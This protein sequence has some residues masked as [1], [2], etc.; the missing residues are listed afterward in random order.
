MKKIFV[1]C[2][3]GLALSSCKTYYKTVAA[4]HYDVDYTI[5]LDK[6]EAPANASV[7]FGETN[8][9]TRQDIQHDSILVDSYIYED[10]YIQIEWY[11]KRPVFHFSLRN[12]SDYTIKLN[13]DDMTFVDVD[14]KISKVMHQGVKYNERENSQVATNIPKGAMLEDLILPTQNVEFLNSQWEEKPLLVSSFNSEDAMNA[15]ASIYQGKS[16]KILMPIEIQ[17]TRNDYT[18]EFKIEAQPNMW[19]EDTRVVDEEK[20]DASYRLWSTIGGI[21]GVGGAIGITLLLILPLL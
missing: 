15:A 20:T 11:V 4:H 14:G 19:N 5:E 8:I 7:Q 1:Y 6:V 21:L 13:W 17:N 12:K 2:A 3:L 10:D 16:M 9:I 18:F